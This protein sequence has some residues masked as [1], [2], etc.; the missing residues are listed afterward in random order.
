MKWLTALGFAVA[1]S[2]LTS[3]VKAEFVVPSG[4]QIF[5]DDEAG[6]TTV[7]L[8]IGGMGAAGTFTADY[9]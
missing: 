9:T 8:N 5:Y 6:Q 4:T 3:P 2:G 7:P 1:I